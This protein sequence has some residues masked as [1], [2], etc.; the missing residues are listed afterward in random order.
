MNRSE[1]LFCYDISYGN[2]NGDPLDEN[3][4]RIDE[5]GEINL[6]TDVRL[7]RTIRDYLAEYKNKNIFVKEIAYDNGE[8]K[9]AK[10]AIKDYIKLENKKDYTKKDF[11]ENIKNLLDDCI[12]IRLFGATIPTDDIKIKEEREISDKSKKTTI[13]SITFTGPVQFRMGKSLNKVEL[14]Q[15]NGNAGFPSE[16]GNTQRSFREEYFLPYSFICF[17]GVINEHAAQ[18]TKMSEHDI[19][20]LLEGMWNGTKNLITR[21]K[22]GQV[23]RLLLRIE[24]KEENFFI[25]D[26]DNKIRL[27]HDLEDDKDLRNINQLRL[28]TT[29]LERAIDENIE[30]IEKIYYK[31]DPSLKFKGKSDEEKS[32]E[33]FIDKL[34]NKDLVEIIDFKEDF[35]EE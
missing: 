16:E 6:V 30:N 25:G 8:L 32:C 28:D 34:K 7:K 1:L 27:E 14:L 5:D 19:N 13:N 31:R 23:P 10:T 12:D 17:Y 20:L 4:P 29:M 35:D 15:I 21:S 33:N 18:S 11:D 22:V 26:L 9:D 24:Y 3:K 2:P